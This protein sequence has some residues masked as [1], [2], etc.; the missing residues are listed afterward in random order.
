MAGHVVLL[1]GP[2]RNDDRHE[3]ECRHDDRE[4]VKPHYMGGNPDQHQNWQGSYEKQLIQRYSTRGNERN[5]TRREVRN[6]IGE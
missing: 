4:M 2:A 1:L 5:V 3:D 6:N